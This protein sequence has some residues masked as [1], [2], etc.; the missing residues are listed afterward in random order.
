MPKPPAADPN[1]PESVV[2]S[3]FAGIKNTVAP[4]RLQPNELERAVNIDLDDV[5]Q[6]RRRRGFTRKLSGVCHSLFT[7][8]YATF[9]VKDGVLSIVNP[10][11]SLRALQSGISADPLDYV[12][13]GDDVY[14]SSMT[15]SGI[16]RRDGSVDPWGQQVS[17]GVWLSPVVNPT[18]TLPQIRGRLLGA[19][20]MAS[21]LAYWNGRIYMVSGRLLWATELY[22]YTLVDK[23]KNFLPFEDDITDIGVVTDGL[24]VGT[25]SA[26]WFLSGRFNEMTRI[27]VT[28]YGVLP[29][30]MLPIPSELINPQVPLDQQAPTKNA[31]VWMSSFGL[32]A[33]M[34]SG[35]SF[36]LTTNMTIFPEAETGAAFFRR[37]DGINSFVAALNSGG[38]PT[39]TARIGDYVDAE[40]RRF[41]P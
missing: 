29:G 31:L 24:Y 34:D 35:N 5:G 9:V 23:T 17:P 36:N 15:H 18:A 39:S 33:G 37:Q 7:A 22:N 30:T 2:L 41:N 20:P 8:S 12:Q 10:D 32:V 13:V 40:I 6:A 19:P 16:I 27:P 25:R 14:F 26:C 1:T 21:A 3:Q 38:T 4:E 11:Y 28:D